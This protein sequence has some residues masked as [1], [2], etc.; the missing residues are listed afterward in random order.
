MEIFIADEYPHD[1]AYGCDYFSRNHLG[2]IIVET[3][4][5]AL[6]RREKVLIT[7]VETDYEGRICFGERTVRHLAHQLGLVDDWRVQS[8]VT[9]NQSLRNELITL[10]M[11]LA[12]TRGEVW[13]MSQLERPDA[14]VKFIALDGTE[15]ASKRAAQ[16]HSAKELGLEPSM[17]LNA[18]SII[19]PTPTE[20]AP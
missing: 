1:A 8:I 6:T 5:G 9:D 16:E 10:S 4:D 3:P 18:K 7:D 20:V 2:D 14:P 13:R 11:E 15:H 19:D 17:L 12:E